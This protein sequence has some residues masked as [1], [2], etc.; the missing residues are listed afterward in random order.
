MFG[1]SAGSDNGAD[2]SPRKPSAQFRGSNPFT[3][4]RQSNLRHVDVVDSVNFFFLSSSLPLSG[5]VEAGGFVDRNEVASYFG[6]NGSLMPASCEDVPRLRFLVYTRATLLVDCPRTE[7]AFA[8]IR[9][10]SRLDSGVQ[11]CV[12]D[13]DMF[14]SSR[15][16]STG[17]M[18]AIGPPRRKTRVMNVER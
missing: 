15:P 1:A 3:S 9:R 12:F 4:F 5:V 2:C 7:K 16:R 8:F 17:D 13:T 11:E 10:F 14:L 18:I 6:D